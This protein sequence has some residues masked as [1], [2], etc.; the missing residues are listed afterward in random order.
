MGRQRLLKIFL[1]LISFFTL[2]G[3]QG[4]CGSTGDIKVWQFDPVEV[5]GVARRDGEQLDLSDPQF[6][7]EGDGEDRE[8]D[9]FLISDEDLRTAIELIE[10]CKEQSPGVK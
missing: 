7:C 8:C 6:K 5:S 2:T 4:G 9:W 1:I 10:S 3:M